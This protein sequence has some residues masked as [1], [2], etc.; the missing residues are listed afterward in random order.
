MASGRW[1]IVNG[2]WVQP[3]CN[4]PSGEAL[5]RQALYGKRYIEDRFGIEVPVA[6][7]V[8]SFGHAGTL[9]MLLRHT[10]SESYVFMRPAAHEMSLPAELFRWAAPD[11]SE[12]TAIRIQIAYNT[13][14]RNMSLD[15]RID[16][17]QALIAERA[18]LFMC[19]Y[20][21]GDHGGRAAVRHIADRVAAGEALRF[22]DP[23]S[24]FAEATATPGPM[25]TDELQF[26]AIGCYAAASGLKALNRRA[27]ARLAQAEA[28][29]ALAALTTGIAYPR[30]RFEDI[31]RRLLLSQ[32]HDTLG[33]TSIESA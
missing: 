17:H 10:G 23:G 27:E 26:H 29:L 6:Y 15:E 2:W 5:I 24:F 25:V 19:L 33:G 18:H 12:V 4:L 7:N 32:F 20:G 8:D 13:S 22:S 31:W 21:V 3:D 30:E 11:G 16:H 28:A 1:V 9:P 14:P